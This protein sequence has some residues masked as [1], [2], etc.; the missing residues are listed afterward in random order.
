MERFRS[1]QCIGL[2]LITW[3]VVPLIDV[4]ILRVVTAASYGSQE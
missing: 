2:L 1:A 4:S 3:I